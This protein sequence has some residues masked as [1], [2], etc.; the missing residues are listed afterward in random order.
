MPEALKQDWVLRRLLVKIQ[1]GFWYDQ[2]SAETAAITRERDELAARV[3]ELESGEEVDHPSGNAGDLQAPEDQN[4]LLANA[5]NVT[6]L[7]KLAEKQG[8]ISR[9]KVGQYLSA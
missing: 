1:R 6:L 9:L 4:S 3:R 2:G 5:R 8:E 7:R